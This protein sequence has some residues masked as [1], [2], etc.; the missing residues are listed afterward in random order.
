MVN[1]KFRLALIAAGLVPLISM[2]TGGA[3]SAKSN[4]GAVIGGILVGAAIGAAVS[5]SIDH[6]KKVYVQ[7]PKP[8]DPWG[9]SYSP[10]S[11]ITCYPARHACYNSQGAFNANWTSKIYA[12]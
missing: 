2:S 6:P 5:S 7:T 12:R 11:G 8:R 4:T 1:S 9:K 10:K 3:A